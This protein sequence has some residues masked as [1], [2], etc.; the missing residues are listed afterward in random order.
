MDK[1]FEEFFKL[2]KEHPLLAYNHLEVNKLPK[3]ES[4]KSIVNSDH[5]VIAVKD[6]YDL[7]IYDRFIIPNR[8]KN[9]TKKF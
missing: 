7:L 4:S 6:N 8:N 3:S 1:Y 2:L 5:C 9:K